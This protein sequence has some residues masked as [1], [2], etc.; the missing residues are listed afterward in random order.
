MTGSS[1]DVEIHIDGGLAGTQTVEVVV[2]EKGTAEL[3]TVL[4]EHDIGHDV[5]D[6]RVESLPGGTVLAVG[7]FHLGQGGA[8]L[9]D[10]LADFA[11]RLDPVVPVVTIGG[12]PYEVGESGAVASAL[13]ALRAAQDE[14]DASAA[15]ARSEWERD[16]EQEQGAEDSEEPKD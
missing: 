15:E 2:S 16:Y 1:S 3:L 10:A 7:S 6:K 12:T 13:V 11:R 9:G 8:G 4:D 14:R 5:L